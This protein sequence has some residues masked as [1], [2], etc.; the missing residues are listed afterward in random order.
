MALT[1]RQDG[2]KL[3]IEQLDG[4]FTY[5]EQLALQGGVGATG[6][7]GVTGQTGPQGPQG[8][9]G[10]S[11]PQGP[12]GGG[13]GGGPVVPSDA[14]LYFVN[15]QQLIDDIEEVYENSPAPNDPIW[16]TFTSNRLIDV[17]DFATITDVLT[18]G[19]YGETLD[20]VNNSIRIAYNG[21]VKL[22]GPDSAAVTYNLDADWNN[23][24]V[25]GDVQVEISGKIG[26]YYKWDEGVI[27]DEVP[28]PVYNV[29]VNISNP[30]YQDNPPTPGSIV[31][32]VQI[33]KATGEMLTYS[34]NTFEPINI[35]P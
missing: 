19:F 16:Q 14:K 5:L 25:D 30:T 20:T 34:L 1:L 27:P 10:Q 3:S 29:R 17:S 2:A 35:Y 26:I 8:P 22:G 12:E 33:D 24:D 13:G 18:G 11:G 31:F 4:N 28:Q 21:L 6:P 9:E 32:R 15:V 7:Q 23:G